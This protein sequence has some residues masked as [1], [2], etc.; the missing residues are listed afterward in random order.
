VWDFPVP[1][2][3]KYMALEHRRGTGV[4]LSPLINKNSTIV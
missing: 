3:C 1:A 4:L 2:T